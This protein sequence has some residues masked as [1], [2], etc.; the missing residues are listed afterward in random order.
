MDEGE[1]GKFSRRELLFGA[2][3]LAATLRADTYLTARGERASAHEQI[4][5]V[6]EAFRIKSRI[7]EIDER[8]H[9]FEEQLRER[10][11]PESLYWAA[12]NLE[13]LDRLGIRHGELPAQYVISPASPANKESFDYA[14]CLG[15]VVIGQ[16]RDTGENIS[17][18]SH[19]PPRSIHQG[20][21]S[22]LPE[23]LREFAAQVEPGTVDAVIFGG[24]YSRTGSYNGVE[25]IEEEYLAMVDFLRTNIVENLHIEPNIPVGP[26]RNIERLARVIVDTQNRT[27]YLGR[28]PQ[29]DGADKEGFLA[30]EAREQLSDWPDN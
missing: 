27:I 1:K 26:N 16:H 24:R 12:H 6:P 21:S 13:E 18:L 19:H 7:R 8:Y 9:E 5:E 10:L 23:A 25:S 20:L 2:F 22:A 3:A 29:P 11:R 14:N 15:I 17:V 30:S 4:T 28:P